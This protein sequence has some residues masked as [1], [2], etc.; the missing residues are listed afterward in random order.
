MIRLLSV[1]VYFFDAYKFQLHWKDYNCPDEP[2][3][4][5]ENTPIIIIIY[6]DWYSYRLKTEN[7]CKNR[8]KTITCIS[9]VDTGTYH[10]WLFIISVEKLNTKQL[11]FV[12]LLTI[13]MAC[14]Q[15]RN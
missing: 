5:F 12:L 14:I 1:V 15:V 10:T 3:S 11:L 6:C 9:D 7:R 13:T 4:R 2:H 8:E